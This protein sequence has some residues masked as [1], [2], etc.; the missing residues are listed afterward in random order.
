MTNVEEI[1]SANS[2]EGLARYLE[3]NLGYRVT[4]VSYQP[5][6][7]DLPARPSEAIQSAYLLSDYGKLFQVYL[8]ETSS[9]TRT[10]L[11]SIL[12]PFYQRHPAGDYLFV[13]TKDYSQLLFVSPQRILRPGKPVP[14][15]QLRILPIDPSNV[16]HTD[17]EVLNGI[18][19]APTE[20]YPEIIR[21]K[22][23][24]AFSVE[25]V[26]DEF[27]KTYKRIL[28][29]LKNALRGQDKGTADQV[30]AFAQQLLNRLMFLYFLQKKGWLK[31]EDGNPDKRY[32]RSLWSKYKGNKPSNGSFY[33]RWLGSLFFHAFNK[34]TSLMPLELPGDI[35]ASFLNMPFLNGGLFTETDSDRLGFDVPDDMFTMLFDR[36]IDGTLP[37]FL[38]RYNF[39]IQESLPLEVE[40]AVD[41]EMLG[42]V[43][44]SLIN[45]EDRHQA[46]IFY[47]PRIEIDYMCRLSLIEYL[48]DVTG[49]SKEELIPFV[50]APTDEKSLSDLGTDKLQRLWSA[51]ESIRVV[52]PAVGSG[53]FLVGMMNVLVQLYRAMA[54][55]LGRQQNE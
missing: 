41:P 52:D 9:L 37:G 26:T 7:L 54:G 30:H 12:E 24:E 4:D 28:D 14:T 25:R 47:T 46:G 35:R 18:I 44:E 10:I 42:K 33:S 40:V 20:Q 6:Q 22:H 34:R 13:F 36:N 17:L 19:L 49:F 39:T 31:W 32:M 23:E 16:Y 29:E 27:F 45:E 1:K 51:L 15:L 11:R 3:K 5:T 50:M 2:K 55:P 43:Y 8:F 48:H 53:S 21:Q 38:E